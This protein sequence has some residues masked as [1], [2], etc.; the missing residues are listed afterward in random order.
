MESGKAIP[1]PVGY[2]LLSDREQQ[3]F[4]LVVE[5]NTTSR[6]AGILDVSPKTVEKHRTNIGKKLRIHDLVGLVKYAIRIGII[7]PD[8][9]KN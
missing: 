4:R 5:G 1:S 3:I 9:W 6:I 7:D 8:L 2:D